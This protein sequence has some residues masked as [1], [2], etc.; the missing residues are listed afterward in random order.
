M[1]WERTNENA[2]AHWT[3]RHTLKSIDLNS[4]TG[5]AAEDIVELANT[6]GADAWV[7]TPWNA[8]DDYIA[9]FAQS[10][11]DGLSGGRAIYLEVGNEVWNNGFPV[12]RQALA[13]G[14]SHALGK[15]PRQNQMRRYAQRT[16]EVMRIW[17]R[18]FA[19]NPK[20]LVRIVSTQHVVPETAEIVLDY[21]GLTDHVDVLATAPYFGYDLQTFGSTKDLNEIF[22]RLDDAID[23]T[24]T[25]A[26]QNRTIALRHGKRYVAYEA[27]QHILLPA[28]V[29]LLAKIER[30]PRMYLAYRRYIEMWRSR[31]GDALMLFA[32][33]GDIG[34][35]GAWGLSEHSGQSP[36]EA[37]KLRASIEARA[38]AQR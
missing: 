21:P 18:I 17:E 10:L 33:T 5:I 19:D 1:D 3:D 16:I 25:Q 12:A 14:Q 6:V 26:Q 32:T 34:P 38:N 31:V 7:T 11:H 36:E 27:G 24:I 22:K 37:P 9:H 2:P 8:D 15:S 23:A 29:P 35:G 4:G 13:E 28:D 30:D 20:R